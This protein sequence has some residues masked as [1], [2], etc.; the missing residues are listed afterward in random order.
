MKYSDY[1]KQNVSNFN[2]PRY[3]VRQ[4]STFE[5]LNLSMMTPN[6]EKKNYKFAFKV[7]SRDLNRNYEIVSVLTCERLFASFDLE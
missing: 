7:S 5:L 6:F 1:F 4:K 3:L 2:Y